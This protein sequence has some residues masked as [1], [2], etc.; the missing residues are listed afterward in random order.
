M[1]QGEKEFFGNVSLPINCTDSTRHSMLVVRTLGPLK[2]LLSRLFAI[3]DIYRYKINDTVHYAHGM[4]AATVVRLIVLT[5][6]SHNLKHVFLPYAILLLCRNFSLSF[7]PVSCDR[8]EILIAINFPVLTR[9]S[10]ANI[11]CPLPFSNAFC[12]IDTSRQVFHWEELD[13]TRVQSATCEN[14]YESGYITL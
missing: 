13:E 3:T 6:I 1:N 9:E 7:V 12:S 4:I 2:L 10:A 5:A 8:R 11:N 14:D